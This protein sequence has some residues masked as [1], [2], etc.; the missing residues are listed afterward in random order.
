MHRSIFNHFSCNQWKRRDCDYDSYTD[1]SVNKIE[2]QI[3][4]VYYEVLKMD[5]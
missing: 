1:N 2:V 5:G 4:S 3:K